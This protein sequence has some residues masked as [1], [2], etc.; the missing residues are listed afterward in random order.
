MISSSVSV[1]NLLKEYLKLTTDLDVQ[2]V[3]TAHKFE[4]PTSPPRLGLLSTVNI[5]QA[6]GEF[7][8]ER[9]YDNTTV[10]VSLIEKLETKTTSKD[11]MVYGISVVVGFVVGFLGTMASLWCRSRGSRKSR[12]KY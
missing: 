5:E 11:G 8:A 3:Y 4:T 2:N 9:G 7:W 6:L 10:G 12:G 1:S